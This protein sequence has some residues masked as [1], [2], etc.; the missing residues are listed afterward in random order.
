MNQG[1]ICYLHVHVPYLV[2]PLTLGKVNGVN[3][4]SG[5]IRTE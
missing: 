4:K 3:F 5:E 1:R 2:T